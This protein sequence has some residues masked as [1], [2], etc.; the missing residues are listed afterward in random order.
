MKKNVVVLLALSVALLLLTGCITGQATAPP[1]QYPAPSGGGCGV[2]APA[3]E[4]GLGD[5]AA[6]IDATGGL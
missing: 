2:A 6:T 4:A 1:P 5:R 3:D